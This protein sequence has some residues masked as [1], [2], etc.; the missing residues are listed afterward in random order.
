MM[1]EISSQCFD[2]A[3]RVCSRQ[4]RWTIL[5]ES[6]ESLQ[7][8]DS[9]LSWSFL[10]RLPRHETKRDDQPGLN[11]WLRESQNDDVI[12]AFARRHSL[13]VGLYDT[14]GVGYPC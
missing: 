10:D 11:D 8:P 1:I 7:P 4:S 12:V 9:M 14:A 13:N 6:R 2:N 3:R 5:V